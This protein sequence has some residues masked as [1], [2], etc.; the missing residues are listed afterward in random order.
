MERFFDSSALFAWGDEDSVP[1][2]AINKLITETKPSLV[3]TDFVFAETLSL[4]TKRVGKYHG[5]RLGER[6]RNSQILKVIDIDR[7]VQEEAWNLYK[8][9]RDKDFDFIDATSFIVCRRRKIQ[10]VLTIDRHFQQMGFVV[11]P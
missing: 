2:K 11:V 6:I 9:Y 8:K 10:E 1:G 7:A 4:V 3:T 5:I